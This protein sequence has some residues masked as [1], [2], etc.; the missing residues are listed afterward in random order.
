MHPQLRHRQPAPV[1]ARVARAAALSLCRAAARLYRA[2][3]AMERRE[4]PEEERHYTRALLA[5]FGKLD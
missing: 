5:S 4:P 1:T 2:A 3:Q